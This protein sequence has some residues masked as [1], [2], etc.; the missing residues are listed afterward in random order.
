MEPRTIKVP[1]FTK[2]INV[3]IKKIKQVGGNFDSILVSTRTVVVVTNWILDIKTIF[4]NLYI[5]N[6]TIVPKKRGRK[7]QKESPD[8]NKNLSSGSVISASYCKQLRGVKLKK[9]KKNKKGTEGKAKCM[10]N[11]L[12]LYIKLSEKLV[13]LKL[14]NNGKFQLTG[15][16]K[17]MHSEQAVIF[18][19]AIIRDISTRHPR[20]Y[21]IIPGP[22]GEMYPISIFQQVMINV[23]YSLGFQVD[24]EKLDEIMNTKGKPFFSIY[25]PIFGYSGVNTKVFSENP[26]EE[27]LVMLKWYRGKIIKCKAPYQ[28][29]LSLL[30]AKCLKKE[31]NKDHYHTF[32]TFQSGS[33]IQSGPKYGEMREMH[34]KFMHI[35]K[36]YREDIEEKLDVRKKNRKM[37]EMHKKFIH[38]VKSNR[39]DI[40]DNLDVR[41]KKMREMHKK[42]IHIVKSNREDIDDNL[43]VRK[44]NS[45]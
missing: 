1:F 39:E 10:R 6:Y 16:A 7:S 24:R 34:K 41:K 30:D 31:L 38:T 32:L 12:S 5:S 2:A 17:A 22:K 35:V 33:V 29:Y 13:N 43:D 15:C 23:D 20:V 26:H 14:Y 37:I 4:D 42:F 9:D 21:K 36:S 45:Y 18:M 40:D 44:M 25:E 28:S 27:K 3:P 11:S 8:P 19:H